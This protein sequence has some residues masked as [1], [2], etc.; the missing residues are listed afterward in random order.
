MLGSVGAGDDGDGAGRNG[1]CVGVTR[2][3]CTCGGDDV[4][5]DV[6]EDVGEDVAGVDVG[7]DVATVGSGE[8]VGLEVATAVVG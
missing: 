5:E 4:A 7:G 2:V 1:S 8:V 6:A 3:G